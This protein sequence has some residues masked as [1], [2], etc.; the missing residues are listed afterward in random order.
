MSHYSLINLPLQTVRI[1]KVNLTEEGLPMPEVTLCQRLAHNA[2]D[3]SK[4]LNFSPFSQS[5]CMLYTAPIFS[6][7]F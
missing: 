2:Y 4:H 1:Y 3:E 6:S 5:V 7:F